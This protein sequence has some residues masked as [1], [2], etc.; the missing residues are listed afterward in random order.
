ME[1]E[2]FVNRK[3][4]LEM[5]RTNYQLIQNAPGLPSQIMDMPKDEMFSNEFQVCVLS[6]QQLKIYWSFCWK[7]ESEH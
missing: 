5:K 7:I 3:R 6:H 1:D 2:R 4:E